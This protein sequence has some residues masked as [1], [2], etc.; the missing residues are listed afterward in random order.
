MIANVVN[1]LVGIV[2]TYVAIL[3]TPAGAPSP[4]MLVAA[5]IVIVVLAVISRRSDFS[6]WQSATNIVLGVVLIVCTL[7]DRVVPMSPLV[8]FWID[9]WV[10]L[11]V[12][13][14]ALWAA[15]YHPR[16]GADLP[17]SAHSRVES[18]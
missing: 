2:L 5:G 17:E 1:F 3:G 12:A 6:G 13:S 4:W 16:P 15:L 11:T 18:N 9:M 7:I 8:T 10:G 14:L